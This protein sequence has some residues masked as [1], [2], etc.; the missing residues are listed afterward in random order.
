MGQAIGA[1]A[2]SC[3]ASFGNRGTP[4]IP[5]TRRPVLA[6]PTGSGE[7]SQNLNFQRGGPIAQKV[8]PLVLSTG[9]TSE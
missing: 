8:P 3:K 9:G 1:Q 7:L 5:A 2:F 6:L 4:R